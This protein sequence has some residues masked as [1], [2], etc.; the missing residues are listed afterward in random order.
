MPDY[1]IEIGRDFLCKKASRRKIWAPSTIFLVCF[2]VWHCFRSII[3]YIHISTCSTWLL[4]STEFSP[5]PQLGFIFIHS[6]RAHLINCINVY[7]KYWSNVIRSADDAFHHYMIII[8]IM[9]GEKL[10]RIYPD[11]NSSSPTTLPHRSYCTYVE[12]T[13]F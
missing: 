11:K 12:S 3:Y 1:C 4:S 7:A 2:K 13:V 5:W 10:Y 8:I 9:K 6:L